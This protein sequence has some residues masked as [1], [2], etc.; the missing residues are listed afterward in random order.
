[1]ERS[2]FQ[3]NSVC[4]SAKTSVSERDMMLI[5]DSFIL[6]L[7]S[8]SVLILLHDNLTTLQ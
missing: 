3:H 8:A 7:L 6:S 1:M 2:D 4:L 5:E